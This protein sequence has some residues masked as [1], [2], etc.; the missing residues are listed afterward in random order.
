VPAVNTAGVGE[1]GVPDRERPADKWV[2]PERPMTTAGSLCPAI[3]D[4]LDA[5]A[6]CLSH[7]PAQSAEL[8]S[9][10]T[11][12]YRPAQKRSIGLGLFGCSGDGRRADRRRM[13]DSSTAPRV[14]T[15]V[16]TPGLTFEV[17][18]PCQQGAWGARPMIVLGGLAPQ[19]ACWYG[20][21]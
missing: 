2:L 13:I 10:Q 21:R 12:Q 3:D 8:R 11:L 15:T 16:T 20:S 6:R 19:D 4:A 9:G 17:T 1:P 5:R 14:T 18:R 7:F